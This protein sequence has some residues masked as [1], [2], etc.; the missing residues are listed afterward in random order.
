MRNVSIDIKALTGFSSDVVSKLQPAFEKYNEEQLATVKLPGGS[1][2]VGH[3]SKIM[4]HKNEEMKHEFSCTEQRD[5]SLSAR[6]ILSETDDTS[7]SRAHRASLSITS[8]R[9]GY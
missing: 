1:Q 9:H 5:R 8:R 4:A 2:P 3:L 7:M 6:T